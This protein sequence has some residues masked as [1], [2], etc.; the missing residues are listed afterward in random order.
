M[1]LLADHDVYRVTV[2]QL[3]GWG[4]DVMTVK[5]LNMHRASDRE[6][7]KFASETN[8]LFVTR[9]KDFG[10]LVFLEDLFSTGVI[11]LRITPQT[12]EDVHNELKRLLNEYPED[13]LNHLFCVVEPHRHRIR[14][15]SK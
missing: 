5:E 4:H 15:L 2:D 14:R 10:A 3:R 6:L 13:A 11:L 7:L 1:R 9:D 12:L 8:W